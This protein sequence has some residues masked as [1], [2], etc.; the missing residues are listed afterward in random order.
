MS[1]AGDRF[2][3]LRERFLDRSAGDLDTLRHERDPAALRLVVHRLAGA[4]GT[5]G[6]PDISRDAGE[7]DDA[8]VE[9]KDPPEDVLARLISGLEALIDLRGG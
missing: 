4:A 5:F 1:D 2:Q 6:Y 8:L 9:G 7:V 3:A